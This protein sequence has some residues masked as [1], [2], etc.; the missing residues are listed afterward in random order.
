MHSLKFNLT[1]MLKT[2]EIS[3]GNCNIISKFE[4]FTKI[5]VAF[6]L[7]GSGIDKRLPGT[8]IATNPYRN[9]L[10]AINFQILL[11]WQSSLIFKSI[12]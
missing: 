2:N 1:E 5:N 9:L 7:L 6:S 10:Y 3:H 11:R 8:V 4:T 12:H